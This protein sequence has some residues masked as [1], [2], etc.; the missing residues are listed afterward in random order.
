M[1]GSIS[2]GFRAPRLFDEDLHINTLGADP[3]RTINT[4]GLKKESAYVG[5]L[6]VIWNPR[7][8]ADVLAFE[9]N[10][11]LTHLKDA[12][13]LSPIMTTTSG[14]LIQERF[15]SGTVRGHGIEFNTAYSFSSRLR[16]D[17]GIVWQ[18]TRHDAPVDLYDDGAGTIIRSTRFNKTPERFAVLQFQYELM[19]L[20]FS[21][22]LPIL[23]Q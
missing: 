12:F 20:L 19:P 22:L 6:G 3:I 21:Q 16:A 18:Q 14:D 9:I 15:N 11:Y 10:G 23:Q 4:P 17:L 5:N 13:Q 2:S 7:P 1:R 8:W